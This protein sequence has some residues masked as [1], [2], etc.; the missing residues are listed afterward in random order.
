MARIAS[1]CI[2]LASGALL[3]SA[4][5]NSAEPAPVGQAEATESSTT[6]TADTAT[7]EP[8]PLREGLA[9]VIDGLPPDF[10][11]RPLFLCAA[12]EG[13]FVGYVGQEQREGFA[14]D[15]VYDGAGFLRMAA[16]LDGDEGWLDRM[17][18]RSDQSADQLIEL[19]GSEATLFS[20]TTAEPV[21][22]SWPAV[23]WQIEDVS[24]Q[25][26]GEG[27]T[28]AEVIAAA[29]SVRPAT[30]AE[31]ELGGLFDDECNT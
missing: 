6:S 16:W 19:G 11:H 12:N 9:F 2:A 14:F 1:G 29:E 17:S 13:S 27:M 5:V 23:G 31:R 21:P 20:V 3:L 10:E 30:D 8:N 25:M 26:I 15:D 7:T 22:F 4:C 28:E 24:F 18:G